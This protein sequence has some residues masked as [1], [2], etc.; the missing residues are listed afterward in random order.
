MSGHRD[1]GLRPDTEQTPARRLIARTLAAG[2]ANPTLAWAAVGLS[3]FLFALLLRT[4]YLDRSYDVF[5]D[6]VTYFLI[7]RNLANGLGVSLHGDAFF[8]HPPLFF[9]LEA[10][11][12]ALTHPAGRLIDQILD[13]RILDATLGAATAVV[14]LGLG[15]RLGGWRVGAVSFLLFALDPFIIR[16][17][18]RNLLEALALLSVMVGYLAI[19][20]RPLDREP[21]AKSRVAVAGLAFGAALLTKEMTAFLTL[22][23][24]GLVFVTGLALPRRTTLAII[25]VALL[26]YSVYPLT[27]LLV[28][29]GPE[30]VAVKLT[31]VFRFLGLVKTTGFVHGG[32]SFVGAVAR[33]LD[34]FA[35]TYSLIL[36]GI[37]ASV[38]LARW[39][40]ARARV[41]GVLG[42][43]A[44][45]LLAY[46]IAFGTLEEQF[47]YFLVVPAI[48]TVP[49]GWA[50]AVRL[51]G[52]RSSPLVRRIPGRQVDVGTLL[53]RLLR[54][55]ARVLPAILVLSLAW[56]SVV[57]FQVHLTPDDGYRQLFAYLRREVPDGTTIG[58]TTDPQEF[59]LQGYTIERVDSVASIERVGP[60]YAVVSTKQI[61]DGYTANG[62]EIYAWL[63]VNG[64]RVYTVA[65]RTYGRLEVYR[66]G[67]APS[68]GG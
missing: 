16:M 41:I 1:A 30:Y 44:Y 5:I 49:L 51:A 60:P 22:L 68:P 3:A 37:P 13:V 38:V 19:A 53:D 14:L 21:V 17:N 23:P 7:S 6:E 52:R 45:A 62:R 50:A 59:L 8:I 35:T 24:L 11:Y 18:S 4:I 56:S 65:G 55:G 31:G 15:T 66:V 46:S 27:V 47:F 36:L 67:A 64:E 34:V 12:I 20:W 61:E 40:D 2:R 26:V 29:L 58:T 54:T 43:S 57:W 39:G 28:G 48:V 10:P 33:N 63:Q 32:P 42:I 9:L 25:G